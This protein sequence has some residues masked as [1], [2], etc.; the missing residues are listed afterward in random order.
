M[1]D[2]RASYRHALPIWVIYKNQADLTT[3][4]NWSISTGLQPIRPAF[5]AL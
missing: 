4:L 2:K 3:H 1:G 5:Q